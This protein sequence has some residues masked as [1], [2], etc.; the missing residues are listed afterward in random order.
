MYQSTVTPIAYSDVA[1]A[2]RLHRIS[3]HRWEDDKHERSWMLWPTEDEES[4]HTVR[5]P[6]DAGGKLI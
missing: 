5:V 3:S 4:Y 6:T 2:S 1:G